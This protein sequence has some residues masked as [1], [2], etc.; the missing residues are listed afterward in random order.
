MH[1]ET[2]EFQVST[3]LHLIP[4]MLGLSMILEPGWQP[5]SPSD[6]VS[7][8]NSA[9]ITDTHSCGLL[10]S[11]NVVDLNSSPH[12]YIASVLSCP[13]SHLSKPRPPQTF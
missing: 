3:T 11:M 4:S 2:R 7:T 5:L 1:T 8:P 13:L 9:E 12:I 10:L 6:P